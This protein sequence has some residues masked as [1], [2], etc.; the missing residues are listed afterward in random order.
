[1][2]GLGFFL[3][4]L[5]DA[6]EDEAC[7]N[8]VGNA[9]AEGHEYACEEGGTASAKSVQLISLEEDALMTPPATRAG[10]VAG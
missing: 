2:D 7:R 9:V 3:A 10:A 4:D 6:V 1:M 8:A 5:D